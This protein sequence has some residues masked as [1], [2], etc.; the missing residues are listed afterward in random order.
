M[1]VEKQTTIKVPAEKAFSY[2]A[3]ISKHGEW[4]QA[5]HKQQ[6]TKTSEGPIGKGSTF[7]SIGHQ[8]GTNEDTVTI[9]EHQPNQHLVYESDGKAGLIRHE[10]NVTPASDGVQVSKSMEV[11]K[12]KFP[13]TIFA[14]IVKTFVLPGALAGDLARIKAKLEGS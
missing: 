2:L 6:I 13:F 10:F 8:F 5:A 3:D 11:I 14:P 1:A 9:T 12:P 7:K 4:G